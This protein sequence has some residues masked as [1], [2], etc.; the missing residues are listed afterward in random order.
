MIPAP[1]HKYGYTRRALAVFMPDLP[2]G[3]F[4]RTHAPL[5]FDFTMGAIYHPGDVAEFY[6]QISEKP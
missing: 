6:D 4:Y 5:D 1:D 3:E 2:L